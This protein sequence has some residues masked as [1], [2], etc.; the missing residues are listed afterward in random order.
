MAVFQAR[1]SEVEPGAEQTSGLAHL[2]AV[3]FLASRLAPVLI[4]R[5][6]SRRVHYFRPTIPTMS[7]MVTSP[8]WMTDFHLK[9]PVSVSW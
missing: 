8:L 7:G 9:R 4:R 2:A 3:S 6:S 1:E 5:H